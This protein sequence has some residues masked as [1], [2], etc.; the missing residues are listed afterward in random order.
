[1]SPPASRHPSRSTFCCVLREI[2]EKGGGYFLPD[3]KDEVS[4]EGTFQGATVLTP[5]VGYYETPV[6]VADFASLYP[7]IIRTYNLSPE[8]YVVPGT[9]APPES[10]VYLGERIVLKSRLRGI[11]PA[12]LERLARCRKEAK[13]DI[14]DWGCM[15]FLSESLQYTSRAWSGEYLEE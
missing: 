3:M 6:V 2:K 9:A 15:G 11:L 4:S 7:S 10:A 14:Y 8:T 1:M 5:E 12:V 13:R